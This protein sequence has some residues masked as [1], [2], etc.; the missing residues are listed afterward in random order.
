MI[1]ALPH[2]RAARLWRALGIEPLDAARCGARWADSPIVNLH[3]VYDRRVCEL[4]FAAGV[5]TP[6]QYVFDRSE[7]GGVGEGCQYLAVSLSGAEREMGMSVDALRE[8]YLPALGGALPAGARGARG[9]LPGDPRA[10]RDVPRAAGRGGAA[11]GPAGP[12]FRGSCWR[13]RGRTR[14]GRRRW[15]ARC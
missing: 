14:A 8:R 10:R 12:P 1:V 7:A 9:A 3:V 2:A 4:P 6:V 5:G 15:R 11:A 13:V